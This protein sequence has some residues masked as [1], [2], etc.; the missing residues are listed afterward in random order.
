MHQELH[1]KASVIYAKKLGCSKPVSELAFHTYGT[2]G[3]VL[4]YTK[5]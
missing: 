2:D 1:Q 3:Q 4:N 5:V